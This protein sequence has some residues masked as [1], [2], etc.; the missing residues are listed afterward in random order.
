MIRIPFSNPLDLNCPHP[1]QL[2][3]CSKQTTSNR[4]LNFW[5]LAEIWN[6]PVEGRVR[7]GTAPILSFPKKP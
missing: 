2:P 4:Q 3:S 6:S 5:V 7:V 1:D